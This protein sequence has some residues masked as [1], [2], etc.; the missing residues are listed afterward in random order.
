[1]IVIVDLILFSEMSN[2]SKICSK[3]LVLIIKIF[4]N[5]KKDILGSTKLILP[6][7]GSFDTGMKNIKKDNILNTIEMKVKKE[8]TSILGICLGMQMMF[9][10]SEEGKEKGLIL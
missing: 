3:K 5:K 8:L 6:G 1:M 10:K 7:V 2:V 4:S 9:N